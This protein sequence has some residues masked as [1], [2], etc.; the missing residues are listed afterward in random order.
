MQF[1]D[2]GRCAAI[3]ARLQERSVSAREGG[4]AWGGGAAREGE[5]AGAGGRRAGE[6]RGEAGIVRGG[7]ALAILALAAVCVLG[8]AQTAAAA[9]PPKDGAET[10]VIRNDRGGRIGKRAAEIARMER[11]GTRVELR[12]AVCLS[13][14]TMF[15]GMANACIEPRT[16]FGFHGPSYYGAKLPQK[17][18][19]YWSMVIA[20]HY[21]PALRGWY[22]REGRTRIS[23]FHMIRGAELI[24]IGI[25]PC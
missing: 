1:V 21:P 17:Q 12:G 5:P 4:A 7:R 13:S 14:C 2:V 15:L 19:D 10:V 18:F 24:R 8:C 25:R 3:V 6:A 9:R 22:M 20:A 23:G 11:Q 16:R